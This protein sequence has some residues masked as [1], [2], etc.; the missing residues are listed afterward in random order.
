MI[1]PVPAPYSVHIAIQKG[2]FDILQML[3]PFEADANLPTRDGQTPFI[4]A[5]LNGDLQCAKY[6][7]ECNA[8]PYILDRNDQSCLNLIAAQIRKD[9]TNMKYAGIAE[10][11]LGFKDIFERECYSVA[12]TICEDVNTITEYVEDA[13]NQGILI[14][15]EVPM[16]LPRMSVSPHCEVSNQLS[17]MS[18]PRYEMTSQLPSSESSL[19]RDPGV[20]KPLPPTSEPPIETLH[21]YS[22]IKSMATQ[23]EDNERILL[24]DKK[25]YD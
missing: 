12:E 16:Q 4:L 17:R 10:I 22:T 11:V 23:E 19:Y 18:V 15:Q 14:E 7:L 21:K 2:N 24:L 25:K 13:Y 1:L 20:S 5:C 3:C 8:D 6:L 9:R